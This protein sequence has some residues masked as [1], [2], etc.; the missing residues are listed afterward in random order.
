MTPMALAAAF[1]IPEYAGTGNSF[2]TTTPSKGITPCH[3]P[4]SAMYTISPVLC[5]TTEATPTSTE[6]KAVTETQDIKA[7]DGLLKVVS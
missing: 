7:L 2:L 5:R 3:K 6:L 1:S 4:L